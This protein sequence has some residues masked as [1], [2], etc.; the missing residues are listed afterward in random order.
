MQNKQDHKNVLI[1]DMENYCLVK[2][3][4]L[5]KRPR[6]LCDS[7]WVRAAVC[8]EQQRTG[9]EPKEEVI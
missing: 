7:F 5:N 9:N 6:D 4:V 2:R 8:E 3:V 1:V